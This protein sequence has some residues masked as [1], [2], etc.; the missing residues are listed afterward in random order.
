MPTEQTDAPPLFHEPRAVLSNKAVSWD[1]IEFVTASEDIR[2]RTVWHLRPNTHSVVI[3]LAGAMTHFTSKIEGG[4][5]TRV[6]PSPGEVWVVPAGAAYTAE[7]QGD[8]VH[9]AE[10][11]I[12]PEAIR[13]LLSQEVSA[14]E[15]TPRLAL[16]DEFI[17]QAA[18]RL[19]R[20]IGDGDDLSRMLAQSLG[21]SI[22]YHVLRSYTKQPEVGTKHPV[23]AREE[24]RLLDEYIHDNIGGPILLNK[25]A[26]IAGMTP[27]NFL[28]AFKDSFGT[29]PA[30]YI[31]TRRITRVRAMLAYSDLDITGIAM[32]T[33]FSSHSHLSTTFK[34]MTGVRPRDFRNE[35]R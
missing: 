18:R 1:G 17:Y 5:V 15:L 29:T 8:F 24:K 27:H 31:V 28:R 20:A 33:G 4:D 2:K 6:P 11:R 7:S 30:N 10:I 26:A 25:L 14:L 22:A 34:R 12:P 35:F 13:H 21:L 23:L 32:A 16:N 9:Y 19:D 3:H